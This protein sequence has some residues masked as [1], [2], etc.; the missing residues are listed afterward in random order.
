MKHAAAALFTLALGAAP[1]CAQDQDDPS[2]LREGW[3]LLSEGS[4]MILEGLADEMQPFV[5]EQL[6]PFFTRLTDL[7]DDVALY[8]LPEML[9]NGDIIIRR[10][11]PLDPDAPDSE[12]SATD[13]PID[14]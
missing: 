13:S 10:R 1:A 6:V 11:E 14:L 8:E 5:D 9:P 7:I 2:R 3:G 12:G 4:R